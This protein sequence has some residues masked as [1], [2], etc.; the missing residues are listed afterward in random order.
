MTYVVA[1]ERWCKYIYIRRSTHRLIIIVQSVQPYLRNMVFNL[2][3]VKVDKI[4]FSNGFQKCAENFLVPAKSGLYNHKICLAYKLP[5]NLEFIVNVRRNVRSFNDL[6]RFFHLLA[7]VIS[8]K[9]EY[10]PNTLYNR[11]LR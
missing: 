2:K 1:G 7:L 3:P 9:I 5:E 8:M 11:G 10:V 4:T 6:I